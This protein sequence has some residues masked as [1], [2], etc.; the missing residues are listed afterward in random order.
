MIKVLRRPLDSAHDA[1]V[2]ERHDRTVD[3][4][5]VD[6]EEGVG[7]VEPGDRRGRGCPRVVGAERDE[8]ADIGEAI[9]LAEGVAGSDCQTDETET[10]ADRSDLRR[11]TAFKI[12]R[13]Q[14]CPVGCRGGS[15]VVGQPE[16]LRWLVRGARTPPVRRVAV[17]SRSG[18]RA[19]RRNRGR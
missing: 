11:G 19:P 14:R 4:T 8:F 16:T 13:V 2:T 6:P 17:R 18:H 10:L 12:N 15:G 5:N 9:D 1:P 7:L 3:G